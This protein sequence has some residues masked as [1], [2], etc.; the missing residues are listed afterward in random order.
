[1][2]ILNVAHEV[3]NN[4]LDQR[5]R[6]SAHLI[7][8]RVVIWDYEKGSYI[9]T[10]GYFGKPVGIRKPKSPRFNRPLELSLLEAL[11][12][13]EK[14]IISIYSEKQNLPKEEF[15]EFCQ[16]N[17]PKFID[18][19]AVYTD[20]RSKRYIVRPGLKFGT[21]F[22]VYRQGPG[23]DHAPFLVSIFPQ[24]SKLEPIDLVKA[25]RL[26][27]SVRKRYVIATVLSDNRVKYYIFQWNKP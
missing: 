1:M 11:Y 18:L 25:G 7:D 2:E 10:L 19:Y 20:L 26:A 3:Q 6:I 12:L 13:K 14:E 5:E 8:K 9:Y 21:D 22:A 4:Q 27:T 24:K 16:K 15:L 17:F 23:I